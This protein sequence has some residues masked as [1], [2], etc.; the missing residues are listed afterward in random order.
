MFEKKAIPVSERWAIA[1]GTADSAELRAL[2]LLSEGLS[3]Y[4]TEYTLEVRQAS[5]M[6]EDGNVILIG[7]ADSNPQITALLGTQELPAQGYRLKVMDRPGHA[8]K[9]LVLIAGADLRGLLYG[10][11]DFLYQYLP[12][13]DYDFVRLPS[14]YI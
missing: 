2:E 12:E 14:M 11:I 9:Q 3:T 5:E 10:C 4:V 1:Y 6:P 7:M 13:A 8:G